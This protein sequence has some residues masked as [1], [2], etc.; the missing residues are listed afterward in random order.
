M[1][2]EGLVVGGKAG[3]EA[4]VGGRRQEGSEEVGGGGLHRCAWMSRGVDRNLEILGAEWAGKG[5]WFGE[6]RSTAGVRTPAEEDGD[7]GV[8]WKIEIWA[9]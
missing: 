8:R 9:L 4:S 3:V 7:G 2:G 5:G 6:T 1:G